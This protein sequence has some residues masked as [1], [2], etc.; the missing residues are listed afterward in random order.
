MV[1]LILE[2]MEDKEFRLL[3]MEK[4]LM[5]CFLFPKM[6][7]ALVNN[8]IRLQAFGNSLKK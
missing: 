4:D 8:L 7:K 5:E 6:T 1:L 2:F 3:M